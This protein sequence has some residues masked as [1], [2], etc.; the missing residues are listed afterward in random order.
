MRGCLQEVP[1]PL[2]RGSRWVTT[3]RRARIYGLYPQ[4][5]L[6]HHSFNSPLATMATSGDQ[7]LQDVEAVLDGE[8][9][10]RLEQLLEIQPTR[11]ARAVSPARS[12]SAY[13]G[14]GAD[15]QVLNPAPRV[16]ILHALSTSGAYTGRLARHQPPLPEHDGETA[17]AHS[18]RAPV[19][20]TTET[21]SSS[22]KRRHMSR[23]TRI[24]SVDEEE[25]SETAP[26]SPAVGSVEQAVNTSADERGDLRELEVL[27]NL[28]RSAGRNVN[29]WDWLEGFRGSLMGG[30]EKPV[31]KEQDAGNGGENGQGGEE[32]ADEAME[33]REQVAEPEANERADLPED[34]VEAEDE[35]KAARLHAVFVRFCEEARMLGLVRARGRAKRA[36][37]VVKSIELV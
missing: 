6:L 1:L 29:L 15:I 13:A 36:D 30:N 21:A 34:E 14:T 5:R 8:E 22:V 33:G 37:E 17:Q 18:T 2:S 16:S 28:W 10:G 24:T 20:E 25:V 11:A 23:R 4:W 32:E 12:Y 35:E 3:L 19:D 27:F 7:A 26:P 31:R 9:G